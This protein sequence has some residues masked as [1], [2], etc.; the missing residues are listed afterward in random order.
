[1]L[2]KAK[3]ISTDTALD[4]ILK[5]WLAHNLDGLAETDKGILERITEIDKRIQQQMIV[6]RKEHSV[7]TG[8]PY[9]REFKRPM[10]YKELVEWHVERFGISHRQAYIDIEHA[11]Q[12]FLST[13]SREDK[14]FARG[15]MIM[16]GEEMMFEAASLGDF[17][18]AAAFYKELRL[19]RQLDKVDKTNIDPSKYQPVIP[20]IVN[21][22]SELGFEKMDNPDAIVA[23]LRKSFKKG[24]V[25]K[26]L[27]DSEEVQDEQGG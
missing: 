8:Q 13:E 20:R 17:K 11:K 21:D 24:V 22:P 3:D 16:Q 18:S 26:M 15:Q 5:A 23:E 6:K 19:L 7:V 25:D 14:E 2:I 27:E 9:E 10:R 1:M 12:F 4:R